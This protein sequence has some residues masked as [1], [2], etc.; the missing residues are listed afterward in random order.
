MKN[1]FV[2]K[3]STN[4]RC[5]PLIV[6]SFSGSSGERSVSSGVSN[7]YI[8]FSSRKK[9]AQLPFVNWLTTL[10]KSS[11]VSIATVAKY[12]CKHAISF[13]RSEEH[14]SELQSRGH[15]VCRL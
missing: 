13:R 2:R 3:F 14:T 12:V 15:L 10:C 7:K 11:V 4:P 6:L 8:L 9:S 5:D 1:M